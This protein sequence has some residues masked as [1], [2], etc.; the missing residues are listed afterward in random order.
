MR[1]LSLLPA[2][3]EIVYLLGQGDQL[4]GVSHECDYP[5]KALKLP[6]ITSSPINNDLSSAEIDQKVKNL[7]HRGNGVYHIHEQKLKKLRPDIILTQE[8][9]DVCAISWTEVKKAARV[10]NGD[11]KI[12]SLEPE[13]LGDIFANIMLV[14]ESSRKSQESRK[15]ING[16]KK[17][18]KNLDSR[19]KTLATKKPRVLV[20]E[21]LD[22]LMVAG[23][24]VPEMVEKAFGI[25]LISKKGKKSY[26]ITIDQII[27]INPD[28]IIFAPCGFS[29][30]RIL[31]EKELIES[32]S[33]NLK[34]KTRN[35]FLV[36]GNSYLTRPGP[37]VIDGIEIFAEIFHSEIFPRK[38][39][40]NDW[41][42][43]DF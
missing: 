22:P 7:S 40:L 41:R 34:P 16:L 43:F 26:P 6:K 13:S 42:E 10:L 14:G 8:I 15:I 12:I 27:K 37:R 1:I 24:W 3:T 18:L 33:Y 2:A 4:I 35:L 29:I 36:D 19:L 11:T 5:R 21:W 38:H 25:N 17:R 9:C 23:H 31:K 39:T 20:I 30:K 28:I 32:I